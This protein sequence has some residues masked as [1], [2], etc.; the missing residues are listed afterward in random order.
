L[1]PSVS[2]RADAP[3]IYRLLN[4]SITLN[5][6]YGI[7]LDALNH[8]TILGAVKYPGVYYFEGS[9]LI[10]DIVKSAQPFPGDAGAAHT[11]GSADLTKVQ[12]LSASREG[13]KI[14]GPLLVNFQRYS[15]P[16][17]EGTIRKRISLTGGVIHIHEWF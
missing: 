8:I 15:A 4:G 1:T 13:T 14:P 3:R 6:G 10:E 17:P 16:S 2:I 11:C 9:A 5:S 12:I 7:D